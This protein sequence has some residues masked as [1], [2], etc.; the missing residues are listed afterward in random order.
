MILQE[1]KRCWKSK[2]NVV[3]L[4]AMFLALLLA[5]FNILHS[6][7]EQHQNIEKILAEGLDPVDSLW[8]YGGMQGT[9]YFWENLFTLYHDFIFLALVLFVIGVGL[10]VSGKLFS[11]L[12]TGYGTFVMTRMSYKTYFKQALIAQ[13][14]YVITFLLIFFALIFISLL[15]VEGGPIQITH[16]SSIGRH[17]NMEIWLFLLIH[18]GFILHLAVSMALVTLLASVSFVFFKN[19]Y[20]ISFLPVGILLGSFVLASLFWNIN[21]LTYF[22]ARL[23]TYEYSL[24]TFVN[25][26]SMATSAGSLL[27]GLANPM[28]LLVMFFWIYKLNITKFGENYL[29]N[30]L[31]SM[32]AY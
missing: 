26:F 16:L 14:L 5:Y 13:F 15:I 18:F 8:T 31:E 2:M 29:R 20:I 25:F 6:R 22:I 24:R 19:R 27:F 23:L 32:V 21:Q 7:Y 11:A 28:L 12:E 30:Y 9:L 4:G 3:M 17:G 1:F 10:H